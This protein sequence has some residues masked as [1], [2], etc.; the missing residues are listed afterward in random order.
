MSVPASETFPNGCCR[1]RHG[2]HTPHIT[3]PMLKKKGVQQHLLWGAGMKKRILIVCPCDCLT[4]RW[5]A[6]ICADS[7]TLFAARPDHFQV[8]ILTAQCVYRYRARG[9]DAATARKVLVYSFGAEV[10]GQ[11]ASQQLRNRIQAA[12]DR[13]LANVPILEVPEGNET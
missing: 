11:F 4:A 7:V 3:L 10:T 13:T 5:S 2:P 9:V 6:W 8:C 1:I 12:V